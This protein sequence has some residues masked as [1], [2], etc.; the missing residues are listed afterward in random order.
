M[1]EEG[2]KSSIQGLKSIIEVIVKIL[3]LIL[4]D[5]GSLKGRL[6]IIVNTIDPNRFQLNTTLIRDYND[7]EFP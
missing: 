2:L 6:R 7:A 3:L 1:A 5:A 4:F